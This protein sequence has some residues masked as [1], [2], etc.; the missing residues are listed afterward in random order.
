[1]GDGRRELVAKFVIGGRGSQKLGRGV[2]AGGVTK[3]DKI[4]GRELQN[5]FEEGLAN[6][7]RPPPPHLLPMT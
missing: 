4:G 6:F 5:P 3:S 7:S 1:M 2:Y